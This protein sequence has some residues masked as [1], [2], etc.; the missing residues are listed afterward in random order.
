MGARLM[1]LDVVMIVSLLLYP[2]LKRIYFE[3]LS[4]LIQTVRRFNSCSPG[5]RVGR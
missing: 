1:A 4:P 3:C 2:T 5:C